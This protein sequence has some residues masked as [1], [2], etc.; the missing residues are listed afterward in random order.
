MAD[1]A[2]V[3]MDGTLICPPIEA[4]I[5]DRMQMLQR[6]CAVVAVSGG[7]D[8]AVV[9]A[10][11]VRALGA[12]RVHL[13]HMPERDSNP[14]HRQHARLLA[15]HLGAAYHVRP[16]TG[17]LRAAGSYRLLP[18]AYIPCRGLRARLVRWAQQRLQLTDAALL[19]ERLQPSGSSWLA[20]GNA[21]AMAKHRMRMVWVYQF[22]EAHNALVVGAANRT[23]WLTG[24]FSRWGVDHCADVMP[25]LHLFRSQVEALAAYL[26]LPA[27]IRQKAADPDLMPG[28]ADKGRLLGDVRQ[29]DAVLLGLERG[30]TPKRLAED[31]APALVTRIVTLW[32]RSRPMR[33]SPYALLQSVSESPTHRGGPP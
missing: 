22:A 28:V 32:E 7:L 17:M 5:R 12:E 1:M 4:L 8:S 24:T 9:A 21:Y 31:F 18:L 6:G 10:L 3:T 15:R 25:I 2:T 20:R 27:V 30:I 14:L 33:E 11:T 19:A 29:V 13:L 23:E 16:I 26:G